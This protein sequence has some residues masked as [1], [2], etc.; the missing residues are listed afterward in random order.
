MFLINFDSFPT[1]FTL[2]QLS[3]GQS[4]RTPAAVLAALALLRGAPNGLASACV[5]VGLPS[6]L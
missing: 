3:P 4:L 5:K 2:T 6:E 1:N